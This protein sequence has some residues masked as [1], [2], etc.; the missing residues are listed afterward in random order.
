MFFSELEERKKRFLTALKIAFPTIFLIIFFLYILS[1]YEFKSYTIVLLILLIP[2]YVYYTVYLVYNGFYTSLIDETTKT[3]NRVQIL[4]HIKNEKDREN[5]SL[6]LLHINNLSDINERYGISNGDILLKEFIILLKE[7]LNNNN[8]KNVKIGRYSGDRFLLLL[9]S[10]TKELKHIFTL[11]KKDIQHNGILNIEVKISFSLLKLSYDKDVN[12]IIEKLFII[13]NEQKENYKI[14]SNVKLNEFAGVIEEIIQHDNL[15]FRY[16]PSLNMRSNK[17]VLL[18]V[19]T[20]LESNIY[21]TLTKQQLQRVVNY[22]GY[23]KKFSERVFSLLLDEIEPLLETNVNFSIEV[24]PIVLRNTMFKNY[25]VQLFNKK[26]ID[27]KRFVLE[28]TED[29]TYEDMNRFKEILQSYQENGFSIAFSNFGGDNCS[30]EYIKYLPIDIIKFDIEFTKKLEDIK[31][32]QLLLH[33]IT[34]AR[35][36]G[37]MSMVKFVDKDD[38]FEQLRIMEVDLIQGFCVSKPKIIEEIIDEIR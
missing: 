20:R 9:N 1:F 2:I 36:L 16:Q 37:I 4:K 31:F 29:K 22:N 12:N 33:Y 27:P 26:N 6:I 10:S 35:S 34:L 19:L 30:F 11:F 8:F 14:L 7:F 25:L 24:S 5:Y 15:N 32:Q 17:I 3:F 23:E 38:T 28:F 13:L 21:G 18:E